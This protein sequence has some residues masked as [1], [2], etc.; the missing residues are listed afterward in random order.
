MG[1]AAVS[2]VLTQVER[3]ELESLARARKTGH[4]IGVAMLVLDGHEDHALGRHRLLAHQRDVFTLLHRR[5]G[6]L[7]LG[8]QRALLGMVRLHRATEQRQVTG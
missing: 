1:K 3:R 2:I 4:H 6:R 5:Q 8:N 7:R